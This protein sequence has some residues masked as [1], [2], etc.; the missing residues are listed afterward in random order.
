MIRRWTRGQRALRAVVVAGILTALLATGLAGAWPRWWL[1]VLVGVLAVAFAFY[2]DSAI[3]TVAMALVLAWWGVAF[4]DEVHPQVLVAAVALVVAHVAAVV[5]AYGP[6]E[7]AVDPATVRLW[8]RRAGIV[9][10][11]APV[12]FVAW[13]LAPDGPEDSSLWV[14]GLAAAL[15]TTLTGGVAWSRGR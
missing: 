7:L 4:R 6:G 9:V 8:A 10:L 1:V 5:A 11:A 15:V 2:P 3:G 13:E 12:V 14:I